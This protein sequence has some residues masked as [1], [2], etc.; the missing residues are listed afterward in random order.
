M[1]KIYLVEPLI[2]HSRD[3]LVF[4]IPE[5]IYKSLLSENQTAFISLITLDDYKYTKKI[6]SYFET[7]FLDKHL[8]WAWTSFDTA[9]YNMKIES[10]LDDIIIVKISKEL[11]N[12]DIMLEITLQET[13]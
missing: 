4:K 9:E 13:I 6:I 10:C 5:D 12:K 2:E 1:F 8:N 7:V 11:F 3:T